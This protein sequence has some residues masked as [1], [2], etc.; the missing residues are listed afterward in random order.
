MLRAKNETSEEIG[1]LFLKYTSTVVPLAKISTMGD[2]NAEKYKQKLEVSTKNSA[3]ADAS[4]IQ[5]DHFSKISQSRNPKV[6]QSE[7]NKLKN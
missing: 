1:E 5:N 4:I 2:R 3:K 7:V 6:V